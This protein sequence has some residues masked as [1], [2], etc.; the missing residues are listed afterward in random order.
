[1]SE[2]KRKLGQ[3]FTKETLW[4]MPQVKEFIK[5]SKCK[6]AYDPFAGVGDLLLCAREYG[7]SQVVGLDIDKN[8]TWKI[9]DSLKSIPH[10]D[11]AIIVTNPPYLTNYSAKRKKIMNGIEEY[12]EEYTDMY[13]LAVVKMLEAQDYV[14]AIIPE[15]FIN[16]SFLYKVSDRINSISV[17]IDNPFEDTENPVCVVCFDNKIK[18]LE[19]IKVYVGSE[20]INTLGYLKSIIPIPKNN[21]KINFN[22]VNGKLAI[23]AV[24]MPSNDKKIQFMPLENLNYDLNNIKVSSRLITVVELE[25][26]NGDYSILSDKCNEILKEYREDSKDLNFSPF[27]GNGKDGKRRRRL[28]YKTARAIIEMA[29]DMIVKNNGVEGDVVV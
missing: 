20:Y 27:K 16:S 29:I 1:M 18:K 6:V 3:F 11:N 19:G 24:D 13:Q 4:L 17:L 15:T 9:N 28:D 8:L 14:V 22:K 2:E 21:H 12:F 26:F 10:I 25:N 5:E 7:I 23:R